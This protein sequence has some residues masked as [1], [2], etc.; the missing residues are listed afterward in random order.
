MH[1]NHQ[2]AI[3]RL[4][5][6]FKDD[7]RF[8]ALIIGGSIAKGRAKENSDV[9]IMLVATDEEYALRQAH[10]DYHYY[11]RDFTD[12]EDGYVDGKIVDMQF[13]RDVAD[14][15][16]DP[17][18]SAF[19]GTI[20]AFSRA[21]ELEDLLL[22]IPRYR[23]EDHRDKIISFY[24][25]VLLL[26]WFILEAEKRNDIY[27]LNHAASELVLFGGR[28]I[29]AHNRVLYPYHKWFMW[30]LRNTEQKPANFIELAESLLK[31]PSKTTAQA[32][33]DSISNFQDWGVT[34][35]Q[36]V[37]RFMK[38]SEWNWRYGPP[39]VQDR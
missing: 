20:L 9:D 10:D 2:R 16:S 31:T 27:L 28:L 39:P 34:I 30:E 23:E 1:A 11:T 25:Q 22:K 14:H 3:D 4:T 12:Y 6:H 33:V 38:E 5:E 13:I 24:S 36:A 32:F 17:A 29:L 35:G 26:N 19:A 18:R 15:G 7:P 37:V 21:P 8:L